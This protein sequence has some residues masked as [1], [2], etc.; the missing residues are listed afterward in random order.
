MK[1][2]IKVKFRS[3]DM[4]KSRLQYATNI[5]TEKMENFLDC[6]AVDNHIA[7]LHG[8][9]AFRDEGFRSSRGDYNQPRPKGKNL[10]QSRA[11]QTWRCS[12]D[13]G[14]GEWLQQ[15]G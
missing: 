13:N 11:S 5:T 6:I 10:K 15:A 4:V 8:L 7:N 14:K 2:S 1:N 3:G 12:D 9:Q